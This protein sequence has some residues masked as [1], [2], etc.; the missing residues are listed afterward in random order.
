MLPQTV[1]ITM[2]TLFNQT[3]TSPHR[4]WRCRGTQD[5]L[6]PH[7]PMALVVPAPSLHVRCL[8]FSAKHDEDA[9]S[10][11]LCSNDWMNSQGIVEGRKCA[12]F[13]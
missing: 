9:E 5:P 4:L 6:G 2:R 12:R 11:L 8:I 7:G 1:K 3:P 13:V 10:H